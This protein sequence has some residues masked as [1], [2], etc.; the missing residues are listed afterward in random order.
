MK[1]DGTL[2]QE[3][4]R[5]D[6]LVILSLI[7]NTV[8]GQIPSQIGQLSRLLDVDL[9]VNNLS[10]EIPTEFFSLTRLH[11]L[12]LGYNMLNGTIAPEIGNLTSLRGLHVHE[13]AISGIIPSEIGYLHRDLRKCSEFQNQRFYCHHNLNLL[14]PMTLDYLT[15]SS[16]RFSHLPD[17]I[18]L[19]TNLRSALLDKN[20]FEG[21]LHLPIADN[22]G[23]FCGMRLPIQIMKFKVSLFSTFIN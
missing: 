23:E 21:N 19:L 9:H 1:L 3:I 6:N 5:L 15:L 2:P 11:A 12:N 8:G 4:Y 13:N 20:K 22:L 16:N 18:E 10:G 7:N 14:P 17:D